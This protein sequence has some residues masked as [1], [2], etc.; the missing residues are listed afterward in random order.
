[1]TRERILELVEVALN[2][3]PMATDVQITISVR[4]YELGPD[5]SYLSHDYEG[6]TKPSYEYSILES[7]STSEGDVEKTWRQQRTFKSDKA[8]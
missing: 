3:A 4:R 1:M 7:N 8:L 2:T 5:G 6:K